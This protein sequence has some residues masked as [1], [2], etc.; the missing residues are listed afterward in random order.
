MGRARSAAILD[1]A[2]R[3]L[4][5]CHRAPR[6]VRRQCPSER[7]VERER[8]SR[9]GLACQRDR[10]AEQRRDFTADRQTQ[11]GAAVATRGRAVSLR[12]GLEDE[13]LLFR[14]DADAAVADGEGDHTVGGVQ[15]RM[16]QRPA[17]RS[18]ADG[19][20]HTAGLGEFEAVRQQIAQHLLKPTRIA[21]DHVRQCR[22]Q[23]HVE[24]EA[25][26][27]GDM[28]KAAL[29]LLAQI[30]EHDG[31]D[32]HGHLARFDPR[33][34]ED[35]VDEVQQVR[36]GL[37]HRLGELN[38]LRRQVVFRVV[39]EQPGQDE[40]AVQRRAQF[41]RHVGEELGFVLRRRRERRRLLLKRASPLF[42]FLALA[43][44]VEVLPGQFRRALSDAQFQVAIEQPHFFFRPA[45]L[46]DVRHERHQRQPSLPAN[47]TRGGGEP[48]LRAVALH[49]AP[50][51][52]RSNR[53]TA[54]RGRGT[55]P[56]PRPLLRVRQ[57]VEVVAADE[58]V[59]TGIAEHLEERRVDVDDAAI[60]FVDRHA[61]R[62]TLHHLAVTRLALT[63]LLLGVRALQPQVQARR[64]FGQQVNVLRRPG[65]RLAAHRA[66]HE[67]PAP[68]GHVRRVQQGRHAERGITL[69]LRLG[70]TRA[71]Q[72]VDHKRLA[73]G[74]CASLGVGSELRDAVAAHQAGGIRGV[75]VVPHGKAVR[76]FVDLHQ[77]AVLQ[78]HVL[79][80]ASAGLVHDVV[81]G[82]ERRDH[83]LHFTEKGEVALP[84]FTLRDVPQRRLAE[85]GNRQALDREHDDTRHL[86]GAGAG[87]WLGRRNQQPVREHDAQ[88]G[89]QQARTEAAAPCRQ[90]DSHD[91]DQHRRFVVEQGSQRRAQRQR[92]EWGDD[93]K[94][95]ACGERG[96][97]HGAVVGSGD[98][99]RRDA[100]GHCKR[101]V[102]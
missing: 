72:I 74:E 51:R 27:L 37:V 89:R 41:M 11:P 5:H 22:V 31:L 16:R 2:T 92:Q 24:F 4:G 21:A 48:D 87:K 96:R 13:L 102:P 75:M 95:V 80:D 23:G 58:C 18:A 64:K 45:A 47:Q 97:A 49:A 46:A 77:Q 35:L 57:G 54:V 93:G 84:A 68:V 30:R 29:D 10:A 55:L 44:H 63:Q 12:E 99:V 42:D 69:D 86:R 6:P 85:Q 79:G 61:D 25:S 94:A 70:S 28:A 50:P 83:P 76:R 34:V 90:N 53:F 91:E 73:R 78:L 7:Q 65:V 60:G 52:V 88:R 81:R 82:D 40:Q 59:G 66:Q 19:Q 36:T 67:F 9:A 39:G 33:Q 62:R 71:T 1:L 56:Q 17:A 8:A 26:G 101:P 100:Q 43:H 3:G 20:A 38:L 98:Q 32:V 15:A 14:R